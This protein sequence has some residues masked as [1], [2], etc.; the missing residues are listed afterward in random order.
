MNSPRHATGDASFRRSASETAV[1]GAIVLVVAVVLGVILLNKTD[2]PTSRRVRPPTTSATLAVAESTT[3][4]AVPGDTTPGPLLG[5]STTTVVGRSQAE[6][7]VLVTNGSGVRRAASRV[8]GVVKGAGWTNQ[9]QPTT[10]SASTLDSKVYFTPGYQAEADLIA[11]ALTK[12]P[13]TART[14]A[15]P[16]PAQ[17]GDTGGAHIIVVVGSKMAAAFKDAAPL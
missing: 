10:A 12:A 15:A 14:A 2:S 7:K 13:F 6:V 9:L 5:G 16:V 11:A 17:V 3:I 4:A 8:A 1:R